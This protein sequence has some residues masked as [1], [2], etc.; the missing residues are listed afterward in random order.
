M[1][2]TAV[3]TWSSN[4][5]RDVMQ[6][7]KCTSDCLPDVMQDLKCTNDSLLTLNSQKIW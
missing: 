2:S 1:R 3:Q 4:C 7:Q 6:D 5:L